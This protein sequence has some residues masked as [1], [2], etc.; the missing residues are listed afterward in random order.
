M[1]DPGYALTF[2]GHEIIAVD[3]RTGDVWQH[4]NRE[5]KMEPGKI[6]IAVPGPDRPDEAEAPM[7]VDLS[8]T[9]DTLL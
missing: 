6:K 1:W 2:H 5:G 7:E 3:D 9:D 4:E 8:K